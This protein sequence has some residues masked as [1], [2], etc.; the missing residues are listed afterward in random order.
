MVKDPAFVTAVV[1]AMAMVWVQTLAQRTSACPHG[2]KKKKSKPCFKRRKAMQTN[3]CIKQEGQSRP[4]VNVTMWSTHLLLS[5][6][7]IFLLALI[8]VNIALASLCPAL[9][10][11]VGQALA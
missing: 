8:S 3:E 6:L 11:V 7:C 2:C 9:S 10:E 1:W 5:Q 4:T